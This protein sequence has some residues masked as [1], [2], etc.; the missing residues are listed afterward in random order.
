MPTAEPG[1][2]TERDIEAHMCCR[3]QSPFARLL[4]PVLALAF[5][6]CPAI[7]DLLVV[8]ESAEQMD[9]EYREAQ[10]QALSVAEGIPQAKADLFLPTLSFRTGT[11]RLRQDIELTS[12]I[13]AGGIV[14]FTTQNYRINLSQPIYHHDRFIAL[15]QA[16]KR[17]Q[18]AQL[19]V[20]AARQAL[21]IRVSE[22]YFEVLAARDNLA[23]AQTEK[24][25]LLSQLEQARQRFDVGL[26]AITDVQEA[27][28]GYDRALASEISAQNQVENANEALREVTESYHIDL[29]PLGET[30]PLVVPEPTDIEAWTEAALENNLELNAAQLESEIA[31]DEIQRQ[32]SQHFPTLDVTGGHGWNEQGGR[33]G[34][35]SV[36]QS[37]IGV[38]LNVPI[39]EGG[40]TVSRTRQAEHDHRVTLERLEQT[41]RAVYRQTREA[42]LGVI[43]EIS[44]VKALRQAVVSSETALASTRAGF[45]VGTRTAIDVVA[46]ERGLSQARRDYA[47]ARYDYILETLRMKQAAGSLQPEDIAIANSWLADGSTGSATGE[48]SNRQQR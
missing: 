36:T 47:R 12:T 41:R 19:E 46:A 42:Y 25:S 27:Q 5:T 38:E 34:S 35:T 4:G 6:H 3:R 16:D 39:F 40:R 45:E 8:L 24:E 1:P 15:K 21:M 10:V 29:L 13:G 28:A 14:S 32:H 7:S 33:F 44:S 22:R 30:M 48:T 9:P 23:F 11:A 37:D 17:L 43:S 18:Q 26:I 20:L 2:V 31:R